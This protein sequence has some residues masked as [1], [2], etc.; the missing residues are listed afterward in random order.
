MNWSFRIAVIA[1]IPIRIHMTFFLILFLGAYQWG[2]MTGTLIGVAFGIALMA[3]LFVCVTL[4]ELGH[5]LVAKIFGIP[6]RQI[7]LL[8]L[9]GIAQIT[10]TQRSHCTNCSSRLPGHWSMLS[11]PFCFSERWDSLPCRKCSLA[12]A[13]CLTK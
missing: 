4:H 10:K 5:S 11:S 7:V 1:G 9:G 6:V 12:M 13:C 2:S 3:L 8:P